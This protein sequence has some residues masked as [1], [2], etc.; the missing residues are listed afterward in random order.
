MF[1]HCIRWPVVTKENG[2]NSMMPMF[3]QERDDTEMVVQQALRLE[4]DTISN[5]GN[6][7]DSY[8]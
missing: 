4:S 1:S 5:Y 7:V 6:L 3:S 8:W 2:L